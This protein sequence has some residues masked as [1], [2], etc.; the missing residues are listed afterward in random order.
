MRVFKAARIP[1]FRSGGQYA[2]AIVIACWLALSG[3]DAQAVTTLNI[4]GTIIAPLAC[5]IN[6]G[7]GI[8]VDFGNDV[9]TTRIDGGYYTK[10]INYKVSCKNPA[11]N[12]FRLKIAGV[13][14]GF[15]SDLLQTNHSDLGIALQANEKPWPV[16]QWLAFTYPSMPELQAT[17]VKQADTL[18]DEGELKATATLFVDYL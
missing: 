14:A 7:E 17:L 8:D 1:L 15:N 11:H 13:G 9:M 3:G 16:N 4:S 10:K 2:A 5:V 6:N 18:L 12:S